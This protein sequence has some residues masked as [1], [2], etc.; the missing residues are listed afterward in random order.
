MLGPALGTRIKQTHQFTGYTVNG[1][2]VRSFKAVAVET[3]QCKI[4]GHSCA[5]MFSRDE[6]IRFVRK[7]DFGL[8]H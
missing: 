4:L 2:Y 7:E 1:S 6:V 3:R 8:G 5:A